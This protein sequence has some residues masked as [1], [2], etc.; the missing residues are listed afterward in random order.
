MKHYEE[1]EWF[2]IS[3]LP[4]VEQD[5]FRK[6]MRGSDIYFQELYKNW[7]A[8]PGKVRRECGK[9]WHSLIDQAEKELAA[10]GVED[11]HWLQVKEKFGGLRLY[12]TTLHLANDIARQADNVAVKYEQ[13]SFSI[14]EHCGSDQGILMSG[15]CIMV[16]ICPDCNMKRYSGECRP[17]KANRIVGRSKDSQEKQD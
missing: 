5:P 3:E 11:K 13:K 12:F 7:K 14:C 2:N 16:T 8:N 1:H 17:T 15:D 10:L 9:G 6:W 4:V